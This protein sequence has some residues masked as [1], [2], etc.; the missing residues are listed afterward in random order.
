VR[1]APGKTKH[2]AL[3]LDSRA[4]SYWDEA[5]KSWKMDA[6]KFAIHVGESSES[7][8]LEGSLSA[9]E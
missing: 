8:Q 2:I 3:K 1:L 9:V 7:T 4:F 6:G 5:A